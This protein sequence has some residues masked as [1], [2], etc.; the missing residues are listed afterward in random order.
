MV[1][2]VHCLDG[3]G[4][5]QRRAAARPA[6]SARLRDGTVTPVLYGPL[7]DTDGVSPIGS[8]IV[9]EAPSRDVV[10][11]FFAGDPFVS[12]GVW[13]DIHI[14]QLVVSANSPMQI[15]PA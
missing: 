15:P 7:V 12:D 5:A 11:R 1:W 9:V 4:T 2:V 13:S 8:L 10:E 3:P 6:H 14:H